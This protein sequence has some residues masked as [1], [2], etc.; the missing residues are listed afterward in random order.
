M[1]CDTFSTAELRFPL[2]LLWF[3]AQLSPFTG[4]F[5]LTNFKL[6]TAF[7]WFLQWLEL[8]CQEGSRT[9][10]RPLKWDCSTTNQSTA[11]MGWKVVSST[12]DFSSGKV[13]CCLPKEQKFETLHGG[14]QRPYVAN[15]TNKLL[16]KRM[17]MGQNRQRWSK[18]ARGF[19]RI[20]VFRRRKPFHFWWYLYIY[21]WPR[22]FCVAKGMS[23]TSVVSTA[24]SLTVPFP[25]RWVVQ[26]HW[27]TQKR[28]GGHGKVC[29]QMGDGM[30]WRCSSFIS[31]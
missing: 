6:E 21:S 22:S 2:A 25:A 26:E 11:K 15:A 4:V 16:V 30:W 27:K 12:I 1:G 10:D 14:R 19:P 8:H 7:W 17:D 18:S 13:R 3:M 24:F 29:Q 23:G 31:G 20:S 9:I 5:F 28:L